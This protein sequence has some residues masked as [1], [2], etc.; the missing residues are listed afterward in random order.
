MRQ[1]R[2]QSS[3]SGKRVKRPDRALT[4]PNDQT[5]E[6][7]S[8]LARLVAAW[9]ELPE[10]IQVAILALVEPAKPDKPDT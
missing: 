5:P 7:Y 10:H 2:N 4:N 6:N 1:R 9:P 8:D 3:T